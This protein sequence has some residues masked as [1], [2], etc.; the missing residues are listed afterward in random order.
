MNSNQMNQFAEI[1]TTLF[2][3]AAQRR[4]QWHLAAVCFVH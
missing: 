2:R 1:L 4:W 3:K